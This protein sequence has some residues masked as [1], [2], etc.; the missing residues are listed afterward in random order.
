MSSNPHG[1]L[2]HNNVWTAVFGNP[3]LLD[4][5]VTHVTF[6]TL[7]ATVLQLNRAFCNSAQQRL[8]CALRLLAPPFRM[9]PRQILESTVLHLAGRQLG[10]DGVSAIADACA[11]G[12]LAQ[13]TTLG[14]AGNKIGDKGLEA[15]SGA[16]ATGA[17]ASVTILRLDSNQIGDVGM[18]SFS[19][20]LAGGAMAGLT[21]LCLAFNPIGDA[22]MQ[23]FSTALAN[24]AMAQ[25]QASSLLTALSPS[26]EA[27]HAHY[28]NPDLSFGV[29]YAEPLPPQEQDWRR[30][31]D[32]VLGGVRRR[33]PMAA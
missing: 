25:L 14:L 17:L 20:A 22:G 32:Q 24:G 16:L 3:D 15:L 31:H 18:Q 29:Q 4:K 6:K 19:K 28:P 5:I 11:S 21:Y 23:A 13:C 1:A 2:A 7:A 9:Q 8:R 26:P 10:D 12:A 27:W 30:G 33:G